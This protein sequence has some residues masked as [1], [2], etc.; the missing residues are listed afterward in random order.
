MT[1]RLY[2]LAIIALLLTSCAADPVATPRPTTIQQDIPKPSPIAQEETKPQIDIPANIS[3]ILQTQLPNPNDYFTTGSID[4]SDNRT[5]IMWFIN[6]NSKSEFNEDEL[7]S[8]IS[9]V[10]DAGFTNIEYDVSLSEDEEGLVDLNF[11][12]YTEDGIYW[13]EV[14]FYEI[15]ENLYEVFILTKLS[16]GYEDD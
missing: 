3:E 1:K 15:D 5:T 16:E 4:I 14:S 7:R 6:Y 13:A 12:A 9:S 8:Y 11:G 2:Y 10:K